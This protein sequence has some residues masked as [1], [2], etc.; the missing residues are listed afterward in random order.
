MERHTYIEFRE[1]VEKALRGE[2]DGLTWAQIK[3]KGEIR[4][5]RPCYTWTRQLEKEIGLTRERRGRNVYWKLKK[6]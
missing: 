5:T 1:K 2:K 4:Y 6:K 3:K